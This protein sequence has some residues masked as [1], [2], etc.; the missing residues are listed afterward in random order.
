MRRMNG[1]FLLVTLLQ[2]SIWLPCIHGWSL[3]ALNE[4]M[5]RQLLSSAVAPLPP[6]PPWSFQV[7]GI[8][9]QFRWIESERAK[10]YCPGNNDLLLL[11]FGGYTLGGI[12]CV[13]YINTP[14]GSYREV[15]F[16]SSLVARRSGIGAWASHILVDSTDAAKYGQEYWGLPAMVLPID[17]QPWQLLDSTEDDTEPSVDI[18][19]TDES[20]TVTGWNVDASEDTPQDSSSWWKW[21]DLA[22]PSFSGR[23]VLGQDESATRSPLLRYPLRIQS[24]R[25]IEIVPDIG[26]LQVQGNGQFQQELNDLFEGSKPALSLRIQN[27]SLTAGKAQVESQ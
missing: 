17:F 18:F 2:V 15:A 24:P 8:Y 21:L 16:L 4:L 11:S 25:S 20:I 5:P 13:E 19:M 6:P 27:L 23:L 9:Y 10:S 7:Q 14:I 22:L 12:F 3:P 1:L 26:V